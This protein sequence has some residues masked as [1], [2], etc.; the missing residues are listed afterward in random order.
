[1]PGS[2]RESSAFC[3]PDAWS[4]VITAAA[5]LNTAALHVSSRRLIQPGDEGSTV[6]ICLSTYRAYETTAMCSP[7][8]TVM[9][10]NSGPAAGAVSGTDGLRCSSSNVR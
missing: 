1:M 9:T 4:Q 7:Y 8:D 6:A 5:P 10:M 2:A 3:R